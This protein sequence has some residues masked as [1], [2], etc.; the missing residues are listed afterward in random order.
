LPVKRAS[1]CADDVVTRR[2]AGIQT[3]GKVLKRGLWQTPGCSKNQT[4]IEF[5]L[6]LA[7]NNGYYH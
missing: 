3:R 6:E 5:P 4:K 1:G 2:R 7:V